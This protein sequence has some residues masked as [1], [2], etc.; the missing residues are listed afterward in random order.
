[1]ITAQ[2]GIKAPEAANQNRD[3]ETSAHR[4]RSQ[5][6]NGII[7]RGARRVVSPTGM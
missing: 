5:E 3:N 2:V 7:R 6:K 1:M 4:T